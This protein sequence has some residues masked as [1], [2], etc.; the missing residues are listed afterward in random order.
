MTAFDDTG[1]D[2]PPVILIH[3]VG[4]SRHMWTAQVAALRERYRVVT[5]DMLGHG[6]SPAPRADAT[7]VDY[8][9]AVARLMDSLAIPDATLIGFSM[10]ALVSRAFALKYPDRLTGLV[11]LNGV[12]ER[13]EQVRADILRRVSEVE[14]NGPGANVEAAITRWFSPGWLQAH[15]TYIAGLR[16]HMAANDWQGYLTT[17][18][19]FAT[20]DSYGA[21]RLSE[22]A[23][24]VLVAT[25]EHDVGSTPAMAHAL[26]ARIA[27]ATV[28]IVD[29]ARHMMPVEMPEQTN[30]LLLGHLDAI[31]PQEINAG[32][33]R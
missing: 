1:G 21:G 15:P 4:L 12:F 24:P 16:A 17:Y 8:A 29:D 20:Q 11:F 14:H 31:I 30:A 6:E 27:G 13:S 23:V 28:A 3:G 32:A 22:I 2:L 18:R 9:D 5:L 33:I 10:G 26:A 7:L 19:L 25:G